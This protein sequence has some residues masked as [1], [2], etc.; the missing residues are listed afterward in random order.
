M[1]RKDLAMS[2]LA[3][4]P[5]K[6]DTTSSRKFYGA[7]ASVCALMDLVLTIDAQLHFWCKL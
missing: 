7:F 3:V 6:T 4:P 2:M 1:A 5:A